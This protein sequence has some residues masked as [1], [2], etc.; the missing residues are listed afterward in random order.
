MT[1][2]ELA[3]EVLKTAKEPLTYREIWEIAISQGLDKKVGSKGK[4]PTDTL[5]ARIYT[6]LKEKSDSKFCI[7]SKRPTTFWLKSRED[8][9]KNIIIQASTVPKIPAKTV[10]FHERDLHPLLVKFLFESEE[11]DLYC[12]TIYH[13]NSKKGE[14]G[15]DKWNYP[16]IV[17]IHFPFDDYK[18]ETL[19][20]L[21]NL[22]KQSC[23][24]YSFEIKKSIT[25]SDI[26][27][28]YFQAVSNSS[29]ANEGYLVVFENIE[30]DIFSELIRLNASFGIGIIQLEIDSSSKVILPAR[31]RN[32]DMQTL[33]ML[34][35]KNKNFKDFIDDVNKD[36]NANDKF[37]IAKDRYDKILNDDELE[38]YI[39]DKKIS[40]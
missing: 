33:D 13:E 20:L 32:L 15:K 37:R 3:E 5:A 1:F 38:K 35:E 18:K 36:I 6:D 26:K 40:K 17:G 27:E 24:I 12:K 25:W 21:K 8:E 11:F 34:V 16:D 39:E 4:T 28:Y 22:N 30:A 10:S 23:K 14:K 31:Q 7:T 9:V 2:L 19:G 29:W